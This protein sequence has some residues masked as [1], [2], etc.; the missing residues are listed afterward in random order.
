MAVDYAIVSP[1]HMSTFSKAAPFIDAPFLFRDLA[2]WNKVLDADVLKPVADEVAQ[3]AD[4]MLIGY[5][6]GGTRNIFSNKPARNLAELKGLKVR[7]QGAP[8]WSKTFA[9]VG[10]SPTVIAYN[11]VY[12]AIQNGVIQ[13]GENE[14]AG[15]E[16]MKFFEV[17]PNLIM[18][19]HAITIRP[20]CFSGK[21]FKKL[22]RRPAGGD[23]PRRQ[24]SRRLRPPDRVERGRRE[25]RRAGEGRQA[26]AHPV[27]RPRRDEEGGRSRDGRVREGNRRR[28]GSTTRSTRCKASRAPRRGRRAPSA[29]TAHP[30]LSRDATGGTDRRHPAA[31]RN[32]RRGQPL[33]SG[34]RDDPAGAFMRKFLDG[35]Y[36]LLTWLLVIA[37]ADA[38]HPG[39]LQIFSRFTELIPSY[40]WTEEMARFL[41]V[42][43]IMIGA[44][45]GVRE[46]AHFDVDLWPELSP[47][48]NAALRIVSDIVRPGVRA[49]VHLVRHRV[50]PVRLEPELGARRAADAGYIFTAWPLA[51]LTWVLFLGE[52]F[53]RDLRIARVRSARMSGGAALTPALAALMLFGVFFSLMALRVPVAFALGLACLPVMVI[54]PR[55]SPMIL[56]NET[57]K[58]YNSFIL[59]AVPFFLLTANLMNVG[60]ITDRLVRLSRDLVGHLPGRPRADQRRAVDLLRRHLGLVDGRRREPVAR[61][62]SR[63]SVKEGYD[64]VVLGRDHRGVGGAGGDHPAVDPDDR[65]GRHAVGVDRRAVPGRRHSRACCSASCRWRP[66][67]STRSC[68]TIRTIRAP[69]CARSIAAHRWSSIPAL[70]T[71]VII[72]GGKIFGWFTATESAAIAVLY[73]GVLSIFVYREMDV[74]GLY[75]ALLDTG[76]L[77]GVALFCVGTA[78]AFGWLLAYYQIPKALL[79]GVGAWGMGI[80]GTG[81]FIAFVLPRRR[82]LPRRHSGDHHRRHDPRAAGRARW[83]WTRSTSR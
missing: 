72:I 29:P 69:R 60:G 15:V 22:P 45:V 6:G 28:A 21:T 7:V 58:S 23:P 53:V 63:R 11:E 36:R 48:A 51:G 62:S 78:S 81:F 5:A 83:A 68:A 17:G 13:A 54:E 1:A 70:M 74:K 34:P 24:G 82:L 57:F 73:A 31:P 35:Y 77:A 39:Q 50:R 10:M 59:L 12:N 38:D 55:L 32:T 64:T 9:A 4:V 49:G 3:K 79:A 14:A 30:C 75:E 46:G 52:R 26:E 37:V 8:I 76:R 2:H 33:Q 61:S 43:M 25:A 66:S 42:W 19:E 40:I 56:F 18:T 20:I 44:M 67:T 71:P 41:F 80:I 16:A 65:L 47:R 27:R